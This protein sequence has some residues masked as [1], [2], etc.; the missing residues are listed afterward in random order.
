MLCKHQDFF[1]IQCEREREATCLTMCSRCMCVR[2]KTERE[3]QRG[4][5]RPHDLQCAKGERGTETQRE[6]TA[7]QTE[8]EGSREV[9]R[10]RVSSS[11]NSKFRQVVKRIRV[12]S[13][14][15]N[16]SLFDCATG[17]EARGYIAHT[18]TQHTHNTHLSNPR[19]TSSEYQVVQRAA[20]LQAAGLLVGE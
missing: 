15:L 18:H 19:L 2:E 14:V 13:I 1:N 17:G 5:E 7:R 3:R 16:Q 20:A 4:R 12:F 11:S 8:R 10:G 9:G 6:P